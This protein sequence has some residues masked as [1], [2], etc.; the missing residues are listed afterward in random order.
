MSK[1]N[2]LKRLGQNIA[3]I[4]H[5]KGLPQDKLAYE[6]DLGPRTISRI[7]VGD[8]DVRYSTLSKIAKTLGVKVKELVDF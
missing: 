1:T 5:K 4:R 3:K 7:E 6:A 2:E 8:A